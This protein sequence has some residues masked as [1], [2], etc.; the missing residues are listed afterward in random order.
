MT[1]TRSDLEDRFRAL[2]LVA[3]LPTPILNAPIELDSTTTIEV[4]AFWPEHRLIV[5]LD[6]RQAHDTQ[7]AFEA[8]R[9]RD[10]RLA[11]LGYTVL[12]ITDRQLT[13]APDAVLDDLKACTRRRSGRLPSAARLA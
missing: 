13:E 8:D 12:R 3:N 11:A 7:A 2:L 6:S 5:E 10:R 4:D 1:T 9:L